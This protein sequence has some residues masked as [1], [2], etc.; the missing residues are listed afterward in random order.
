M[1]VLLVS[2]MFVKRLTC[3]NRYG[4]FEAIEAA[5]RANASGGASTAAEASSVVIN[6]IW[7]AGTWGDTQVLAEIARG[8]WGIVTVDQYLEIRPDAGMHMD[9][10][11]DFEWTRV[12]G[13]ARLAPRTEYSDRG[14]R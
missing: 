12:V 13:L 9:W 7:G 6:V 4:S 3:G 2:L 14:R 11:L 1:R 8:G 10:L 5:V